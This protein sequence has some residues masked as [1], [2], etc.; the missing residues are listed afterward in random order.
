MEKNHFIWTGVIVGV[1]LLF[2]GVAVASSVNFN[3]VKASEDNDLIELTTQVCGIKGSKDTMVQLTREQYQNLEQYLVE[4]RGRMNHTSTR[5]ETAILFKE[6]VVELNKYGLLPKDMSVEE[7]QR[8]VTGKYQVPKKMNLKPIIKRNDQLFN[9]SNFFCLITG[10]TTSTS[11]LGIAE[12]GT[13]A[14]L[15]VLFV[16]YL[17]EQI[18]FHDTVIMENMT[19]RLREICSVLR[20][21]TSRRIIQPGNIVFG[22]SI[23]EYLPPEFR[24]FPAHGWVDTQ[25]ALGKKSWN[26]TF[27]GSV[28]N[29]LDFEY[30]GSTYYIGATGFLGIKLN[31]GD[32]KNFFIGSALHFDVDYFE[33]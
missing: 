8:L 31:K 22:T 30:G 23:D 15:Y 29:L 1:I 13:A 2:I 18:F 32:G 6:A 12:L 14:L 7:A 33:Y 3:V 26:G 19:A 21:I 20:T 11:I 24:F 10:T 25:G 5:E 28:R 27:F 9:D 4:F 17:L 16:P